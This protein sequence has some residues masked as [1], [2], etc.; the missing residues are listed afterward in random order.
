M[1]KGGN[2]MKVT[3]EVT[4]KITVKD[5]GLKAEDVYENVKSIIKGDYD[6]SCTIE[7]LSQKDFRPK[8]NFKDL[9]D[10][11]IECDSC[12]N[13]VHTSFDYIKTEEKDGIPYE[14]YKCLLCG[15]VEVVYDPY[16]EQKE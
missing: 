4:L 10:G 13:P 1:N 6:G 14:H 11:D 8:G 12:G 5:T 16:F 2:H 9:E 3:G 15:N 7:C